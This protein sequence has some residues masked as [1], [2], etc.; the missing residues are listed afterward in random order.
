VRHARRALIVNCFTPRNLGDAAIVEGLASGLRQAGFSHI[1]VATMYPMDDWS[2][3]G[4]DEVVPSLFRV[5]RTGRITQ[6]GALARSAF[7]AL[8]GLLRLGTSVEV[9]PYRDATLVISVGGGYL[10]AG[11]VLTNL[12]AGL[13]VAFGRWLGKRTI[14]APMSI[15]P[16]TPAVAFTL[17]R[18]F[19]GTTI[20]ARDHESARIFAAAGLDADVASDLALRAP[21]LKGTRSSMS[22]PRTIG[23]APRDFAPDHVTRWSDPEAAEE[24]KH[25]IAAGFA[26]VLI[27]QCTAPSADDTKAVARVAALLP[28]ARVLPPPSNL[29]EARAQYAGVSALLASRLHAAI[30]ALLNEVPALAVTYEEKVGGLYADLGLSSWAI[31]R[32]SGLAQRLLSIIGERPSIETDWTRFDAAVAHLDSDTN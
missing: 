10:G 28:E 7:T 2:G 29:D 25:L 22:D 18:L 31:D 26:V 13:N 1:T 8:A 9:L 19:R 6:L 30:G 11:R 12:I 4:V 14:A 21:S 27:T 20:F 17:R 5:G 15:R 16:C 24:L 32:P 23:W 3:L